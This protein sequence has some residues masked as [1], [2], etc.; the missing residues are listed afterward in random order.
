MPDAPLNFANVPSITNAQQ[1]GLTWD[2]GLSNGGEVVVYYRLT[3]DQGTLQVWDVLE[4]E[5]TDTFYT[6]IFPVTQGTTYTFR[7]EARN[8]VGYSEYSSELAVLAAQ[9]ADQPAAPTT[10]IDGLSVKVEWQA[11]NN[12]GSTITAYI[13]KIRHSDDITYSQETT[14]CDG[15]DPTIVSDLYCKIPI[16]SLRALPFSLQWGS[17]VYATVI[18]VNNYGNSLASS[19]GSGVVILTNPDTPLNFVNVPSITSGS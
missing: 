13:I 11:P 3:Y 4:E 9:V 8:S 6:M 1:I 17:Q 5:I 12:R 18:A 7:V 10:S 16:S 19:E 2:E 15:A 14:S